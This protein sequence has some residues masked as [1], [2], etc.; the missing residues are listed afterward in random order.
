MAPLPLSA[1]H[2]SAVRPFYPATFHPAPAARGSTGPAGSS[3]FH[4]PAPPC[5]ASPVGFESYHATPARGP[6][7]PSSFHP[8]PPQS[9]HTAGPVGPE[10]YHPTPVRGT[11][12][13]GRTSF[14]PPQPAHGTTPVPVGAPPSFHPRS[15]SPPSPTPT[16]FHPSALATPPSTRT[17]S[18]WLAAWV[19]GELTVAP[20]VFQSAAR[21]RETLSMQLPFL[22]QIS[23]SSDLASIPSVWRDRAA[24]YAVF[25]AKHAD[26]FPADAV[27]AGDDVLARLASHVAAVGESGLPR[28]AWSLPVLSPYWLT[29]RSCAGLVTST[30]KVAG[31]MVLFHGAWNA[32]APHSRAPAEDLA[33][34]FPSPKNLTAGTAAVTSVCRVLLAPGRYPPHAVTDCFAFV[35]GVSLTSAWRLLQ[36]VPGAAA[37]AIT[38]SSS[39][40]T[41]AVVGTAAV[42]PEWATEPVVLLRGA[43]GVKTQFGLAVRVVPG[44]EARVRALWNADPVPA[45][46]EQG[47]FDEFEGSRAQLSWLATLLDEPAASIAQATTDLVPVVRSTDNTTPDTAAVAPRSLLAREMHDARVSMRVPDRDPSTFTAAARS[48]A[49]VLGLAWTATWSSA[50]PSAVATAE[51]ATH[52]VAKRQDSMFSPAASTLVPPPGL[53]LLSREGRY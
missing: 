24:A 8:P 6:S 45:V 10:S 39:A 33:A 34:R 17:L 46:V 9:G 52:A 42:V 26:Q 14:H 47:A 31:A 27:R 41:V 13:V 50:A 48:E 22:R 32:V 28:D 30:A 49:R 1:H 20:Y 36:L 40:E 23:L 38:G 2:V 16:S 51:V 5:S 53:S 43:G 25:V 12:P 15:A 35:V 11:G 19:Y 18:P 21:L 29:L 3:S 4:P 37:A 44:P 7:G